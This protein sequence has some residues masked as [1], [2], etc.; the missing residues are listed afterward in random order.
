MQSVDEF[1]CLLKGVKPSGDHKWMAL[2]PAHDDKKRSLSITEAKDRI[3][4]HCHA[5]CTPE[6]I[7]EALNLEKA[8]LFLGERKKPEQREIDTVYHYVDVE[9]KSWSCALCP[10]VSTSASQTARAATPTTSGG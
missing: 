1:L 2:C 8:D 5:G 7:L 10:K 6:Q 3:L 4:I 9:G